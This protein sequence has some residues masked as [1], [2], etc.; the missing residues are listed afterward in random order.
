MLMCKK[1]LMLFWL[2]G[3]ESADFFKGVMQSLKIRLLFMVV[4]LKRPSQ[5]FVCI[6]HASSTGS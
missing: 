2:G 6:A 1:S 3:E 5:Q 4:C